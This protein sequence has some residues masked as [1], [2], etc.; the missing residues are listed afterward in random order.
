MN[1]PNDLK[2]K[3]VTFKRHAHLFTL[4]STVWT[5]FTVL[6]VSVF[7]DN[8]DR[9]YRIDLVAIGVWV[10]HVAFIG[11]SVYFWKTER[12]SVLMVQRDEDQGVD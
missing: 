5:V 10:L 1:E 11:L 2:P 12:E 7:K 6:A 9:D 8:R 3:A 4:I